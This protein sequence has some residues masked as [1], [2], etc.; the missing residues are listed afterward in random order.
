[1]PLKT[2]FSI[3]LLVIA[4]LTSCE[5]EVCTEPGCEDVEAKGVNK[6]APGFE[7]EF[8]EL[9]KARIFYGDYT[10]VG[11][12]CLEGEV[13]FAKHRIAD[14]PGDFTKIKIWN[15]DL[16]QPLIADALSDDWNFE[17][18][19]QR[20]SVTDVSTGV[21]EEVEVSGLGWVDV[22]NNRLIYQLYHCMCRYELVYR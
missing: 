21:V 11:G 20:N 8:C 17:I 7:G 3:F 2:I 12:E 18:P 22:E 16:D 10:Q 13:Q 1:M 6:C 14:Y 4:G 15:S 5:Q 9:P 19:V